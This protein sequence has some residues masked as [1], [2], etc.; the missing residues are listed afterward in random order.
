MRNDLSC[1]GGHHRS[2]AIA[3]AI[4]ETEGPVLLA[5]DST[6]ILLSEMNDIIEKDNLFIIASMAQLQKLF[7]AVYYPKV[8]LLSMPLMPVVEA[9]HKFTLS[10]SLTILTFHEGQIIVAQNGK[11]ISTPIEDTNYTP[12]SLWMGTLAMKIAAMNLYNP[13]KALE[14]TF[15]AI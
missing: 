6:D 10:Y 4:K 7:R 3:N 1:T 2:V 14:A 8:L 12:L 11:V 15:A 13:G 9:L 5:R